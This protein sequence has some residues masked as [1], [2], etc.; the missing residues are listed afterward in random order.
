[1]ARKAS[2]R[3]VPARP[4]AAL[5]VAAALVAAALACPI[6]AVAAAPTGAAPAATHLLADYNHTAWTRL[7]GAP[8]DVVKFA[9]TSDGWLWMASPNGLF[10]FDGNAFERMDSVQGQRLY[11]SNVMGLMAGPDGSLWVGHRFGGI[12]MVAGGVLRV[13]GA[14][15]G[16]PGG[17]VFSI[18]RAPDGAVWAAT[19][20]GLARLAPGAAHFRTLGQA[21]GLPQVAARQVLF[22]QAGRQWVSVQGGVYYRDKPDQRFRRGWPHLDLMALAEAPDGTIWASDGINKQ[23]RIALAP[24]SDNAAPRPELDGNGMHFDRDGG[25]W[26]LK[27]NALEWRAG[28]DA[29]AQQLT[30]AN[31]ISGPLPQTFFQDREG[32][33]WIGTSNGLDRLRRNRLHRL[34]VDSAL[35]HP[36]V[37]ADADGAVII[38]D[39]AGPTR[40]LDANGKART[41]LAGALSASYRAPDGSLWLGDS[42]QR[43]HRNG[44][45]ALQRHPHPPELLGRDVQAM[46]QDGA[47]RMWVSM[48][49]YGLYRADSGGWIR[50]GGLRGLPDDLALALETDSAGRVWV[51]YARNRIAV[52]DGDK[53]QV[54]G[55]AQ[56]LAMGNVLAL[57]ADGARMWAGGE[58]GL[59]LFDGSATGAS[60][61]VASSAQV[62]PR[63]GVVDGSDGRPFRGVSGIVRTRAGELWLHGSDGATRIARADVEQLLR[64]GGHSVAFERFDALDGLHGS[65][66]QLR[67]IPSIA[68]GSDG[69]LWF[70]TASDVASVDPQRIARNALAPPVQIKALQSG[71][72]DYLA[73]GPGGAPVRL[74]IGS[75]ELRIAYTALSLAMPERVRF[76]YRLEGVDRDWQETLGRRE[77]FYTNVPPGSYRFQVLAAN[78]DGVWNSSGASVELRIPPRFVQTP[79]FVVLLA[80]AGVLLL[81]GLYALRIRHLKARLRDLQQE[82]MDE[83]G[84]IARALH[85]TLLQSVQGLI[86][87]FDQHARR[88]PKDGEERRKIEQTLELADQLMVEGRDCIMT[89]RSGDAPD[90]LDQSLSQYGEVLLAGRFSA[91]IE[92]VPRPLI[93][94]V[95]GELH[96]IAREALFNAARHSGAGAVRLQ[97]CYG[98]V[99]LRVH[100]SDNG[101]GIPAG[102]PAPTGHY[103]LA[104]MRERAAAIGAACVVYPSPGGGTTVHV[105]LPAQLAYMERRDDAWLGRLQRRL[106]RRQ[107]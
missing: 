52:I 41:L 93:E 43:W 30:R 86:M 82:R 78:E 14:A 74:P 57:H 64:Q 13:F 35:D 85:D 83:R 5:L 10:R 106:S 55:E 28:V 39:A 4:G 80:L 99:E 36:G 54:Y 19:S 33:I 66:E 6:P 92:G 72:I 87:F 20:N 90:A 77:A 68:E 15:Q 107:R 59:M 103:G 75:S 101:R 40:L 63:I 70:A 67:P 100:V 34:P 104:G 44:A 31:G 96:A 84:R 24:P 88:L 26:L 17:A 7:Q 11:S 37:L 23:Y 22:T 1:M 98:Q 58:A 73:A 95:R 56:G 45:G 91:G 94:Q 8:S 97:I 27:A 60:A 21:D 12:S 46:T 69:R 102:A 79:W 3:V 62:G 61:L 49:R 42:R 50:Q 51:G 76:R 32:S 16:L 53:V 48:S 25:M 71:G 81:C 29:P 47:G 18:T 2:P 65:A 38:G 89:L 105:S 9:Q